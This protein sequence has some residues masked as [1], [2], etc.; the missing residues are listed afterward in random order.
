ML[1]ID[2]WLNGYRAR[3]T[4]GDVSAQHFWRIEHFADDLRPFTDRT[5][6]EDLVE[7]YANHLMTLSP[8]NRW[9]HGKLF[10]QFTMYMYERRAADLPRN[11][12]RMAF[13]RPKPNPEALSV[14]QAK[15]VLA[16]AS[17]RQ[18]LYSLLALNCG[19]GSRDISLLPQ[20]CVQDGR[21]TR[22]RHKT[23]VE[24]SHVLWG[25]TRTI[26]ARYAQPAGPAL[27]L[28]THGQPLVQVD[29]QN[30]KFRHLDSVRLAWNRLRV[31]AN[32]TVGFYGLRKTGATLLA[33][34]GE[35]DIVI[36]AYLSH[37]D[38]S[39]RKHYVDRQ[40][41]QRKLDEA[42]MKLGNL[43]EIDRLSPGS[44]LGPAKLHETRLE[45]VTFG[46]VDRCS[47][48]LSYSCVRQTNYSME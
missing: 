2:R 41:V 12:K 14:E 30:G 1:D 13:K 26:L 35:S 20:G 29:Y 46:S 43:L 39:M 44:T 22:T 15:Q 11:I 21:M 47:I 31:K 37:A 5:M 16:I 4:A 8:W 48:Q 17:P 24:S 45:L 23:G 33:G 25:P 10:R 38:S 19:Y 27:L 42:V 3:L 7:D 32:V 40:A 36:S 34:Q 6:D 28:T 18:R 9:H